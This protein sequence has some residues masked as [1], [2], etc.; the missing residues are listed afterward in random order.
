[1]KKY[2]KKDWLKYS[3]VFDYMDDIGTDSHNQLM[4][5]MVSWKLKDFQNHYDFVG[6][7][8]QGNKFK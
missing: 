6:I 1:M 2:N 3:V 8:E 7:D 5:D 4:R